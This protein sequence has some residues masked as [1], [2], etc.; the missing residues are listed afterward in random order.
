MN[1]TVSALRFALCLIAAVLICLAW[2]PAA[3]PLDQRAAGVFWREFDSAFADVFQHYDPGHDPAVAMSGPSEI[4]HGQYA[5]W[6]FTF[7]AG[8]NGI[9]D[10]GGIAIASHHVSG[11]G[12]PQNSDPGAPNYVSVSAEAGIGL[13]FEKLSPVLVSGPYTLAYYPWQNITMVA[14]RRGPLLPGQSIKLVLGDQ[15]HGSP[16]F[17][18][19]SIA[20]GEALFMAFVRKQAGRRFEPIPAHLSVKILPGKANALHIVAP[21]DTEPGRPVRVILRAEDDRGNIA[22]D[23]RGTVSLKQDAEADSGL[24]SSYTFTSADA[25]VH[26]FRGVRY[27]KPGIYR[28]HTYDPALNVSTDGNPIRCSPGSQALRIFWGDLHD[29]S[30]ISDGEGSAG[31]AFEYARD[32]AGLD[33][34]ALTDH[35]YQMNDLRWRQNRDIATKFHDEPRFVTFYGYEWSGATQIGGNH[36]VISP[37]EDLPLFRSYDHFD[38]E[39]PF[40][41]WPKLEGAPYIGELYERIERVSKDR[42]KALVIPHYRG[43]P[44]DPRWNDARLSPV[45]ELASE[46]GWHEAWA[47]QFLQRGYRMG[48]IGSSDDHLGRPGYGTADHRELGYKDPNGEWPANTANQ[49]HYPWGPNVQGSPLVAV[50]AR[51][52]TRQAIFEALLARH[53]YVTSGPRILLDFTANGHMM[54]DEFPASSAPQFDV[55]VESVAPVISFILKKDGHALY[56]RR[57][58]KP[59]A[60]ARATWTDSDDYKGHFYYV[61]VVTEDP[62][63]RALSSPIWID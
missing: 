60:S 34:V 32:V 41:T 26:I 62:Q 13:D 47:L 42:V 63:Q 21:S 8:S 43:G 14:I 38:P 50:I 29:H 20:R 28:I 30:I 11:W 15:S 37:F 19:P 24:P 33:F 58:D 2:Q 22:Q 40:I 54:G 57:L 56:T 49:F 9:P 12:L 51:E 1:R 16:G 36:N 25:G 61:E 17:R 44:A 6:E 5:R 31:H 55:R 3:V 48:F 27:Q 23:Y 39:N 10:G 18:A 7:T 59:A 52:N 46:A 53:C 45:I 4:E 35:D